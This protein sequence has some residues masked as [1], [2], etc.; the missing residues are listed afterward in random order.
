M[1]IELYSG[2]FHIKRFYFSLAIIRKA[3]FY[4]QNKALR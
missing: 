3:F 1:R 2:K 4:F